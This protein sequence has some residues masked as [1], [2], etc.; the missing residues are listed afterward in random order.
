MRVRNLF[1]YA[2]SITGD[3]GEEIRDEASTI[4]NPDI[5]DGDARFFHL[6]LSGTT[7]STNDPYG[8]VNVYVASGTLSTGQI[9]NL[10]FAKSQISIGTTDKG[11]VIAIA[12]R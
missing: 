7:E 6:T 12:A 10:V 1:L 8:N 9:S 3:G 4:N 2:A 5:R 11:D